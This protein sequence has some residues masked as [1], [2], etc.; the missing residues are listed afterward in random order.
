M[1]FSRISCIS[2]LIAFRFIRLYPQLS[3]ANAFKLFSPLLSVESA[4]R[5]RTGIAQV[6][7]QIGP[8]PA[9]VTD[10]G[11]GL[12]ACGKLRTQPLLLQL[13]EMHMVQSRIPAD[14]WIGHGALR[15]S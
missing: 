4:F 14:R 9:V 6:G 15:S 10:V 1:V 7:L 3:V 13:A 8:G 5:Q 2:L 12:A 11:R